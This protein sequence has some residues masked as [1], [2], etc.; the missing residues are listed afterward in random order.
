MYLVLLKQT[1][2]LNFSA[3]SAIKRLVIKLKNGFVFYFISLGLKK[4]KSIIK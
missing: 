2:I 4:F 1:C 3:K